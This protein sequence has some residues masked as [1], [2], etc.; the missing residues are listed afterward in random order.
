MKQVML[1]SMAL[2]DCSTRITPVGCA[3]IFGINCRK[4]R[5]RDD[6]GDKLHAFKL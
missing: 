5:R 6:D 2:V 4:A 1:L 3:G